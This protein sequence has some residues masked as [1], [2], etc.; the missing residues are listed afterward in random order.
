MVISS[1]KTPVKTGSQIY[2]LSPGVSG[3][4]KKPALHICSRDLN[5]YA[6]PPREKI[7]HLWDVYR[8]IPDINWW[9]KMYNL[10]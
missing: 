6:F 10:R 2:I 7:E 9:L 3:K 4:F 8:E 1:S 5:G